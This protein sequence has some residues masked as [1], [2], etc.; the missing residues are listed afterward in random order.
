MSESRFFE[1]S[2]GSNI[3]YKILKSENIKNDIPLVLIIGFGGTKEHF[4]GFDEELAKTQEVIIFDNRGIGESTVASY[5][6]PI[7][8]ELMAKDTIE[9]IKHLGIK[10]FNLFGGSVGA[11]IAL[12]VALNVP[13]DLKLEKLIISAGSAQASAGSKT[14]QELEQLC[15][16]TEFT[17][18]KTIQGQKDMLLYSSKDLARYFLEHPDEIDK[19]DKFAEIIVKTN[20]KRPFEIF[21]RQWEAIKHFN[22]VSKLHTIKV[23]T[24][25]IHGEDDEVVPIQEGELI[26]REIPNTQ[27]YRIPNVGH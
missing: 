16:S 20:N 23:S 12:C 22:I 21:K 17:L 4:M 5:Y 26:D 8:M 9:L 10:K 15:K 25:I 14:Y 27:F 7:T 13:S 11:M 19:L 6:D 24:L 2:D 18:P 1:Q 3:A